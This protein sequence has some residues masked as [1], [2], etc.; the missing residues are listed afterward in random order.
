MMIVSVEMVR[1]G[2]NMCPNKLGGKAILQVSESKVLKIGPYVAEGEAAAMRLVAEKTDVPVPIVYEAGVL[3]TDRYILMDRIEGVA[4]REAWSDMS[5]EHQRSVLSQ[6]KRYVAE[7]RKIK[8][9]HFGG[10]SGGPCEDV[11]FK[12]PW[13]WPTEATYGPYA[14]RKAFNEGVVTALRNSRHQGAPR[15]DLLEAEIRKSEGEEAIF[16]HG[17]LNT[18]NIMVKDGVV[19]G[20]LDWGAAGYSVRAREYFEAG[21]Q[22]T[23][24]WWL[25]SRSECIPFYKEE[26]N[27]LYHLNEEMRR[28]VGI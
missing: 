3:R 11:I 14:S 5:P 7:W 4:L 13:D 20:V 21:H 10:V 16:T 15:N 28:Y 27:F 18:C 8:G 23:N 25:N 19:T 12:H 17:D 22:S 1:D 6:L 2:H 24:T 26:S 9:P